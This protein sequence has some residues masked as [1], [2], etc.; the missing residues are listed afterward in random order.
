MKHHII[1]SLMLLLP[2]AAFAQQ[3]DSE[4]PQFSGD[5]LLLVMVDFPNMQFQHSAAEIQSAVADYACNGKRVVGPYH[6]PAPP[7]SYSNFETTFLQFSLDVYDSAAAD[8][9]MSHF[10]FDSIHKNMVIVY[11]GTIEAMA[12]QN[13]LFS[14]IITTYGFT[15]TDKSLYYVFASEQLFEGGDEHNGVPWYAGDVLW[16][17][18]LGQTEYAAPGYLFHGYGSSIIERAVTGCATIDTLT[19]A[20]DSIELKVVTGHNDKGYYISLS[21]DEFLLLEAH[22]MRQGSNAVANDGMYIFHGS[23]SIYTYYRSD[24]SSIYNR[25][26]VPFGAHIYPDTVFYYMDS[27]DFSCGLPYM[28][29]TSLSPQSSVKPRLLDTT[30]VM[31]DVW[32]TNIRWKNGLVTL[33]STIL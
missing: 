32:I 24:N 3:N 33:L 17:K 29:G 16:I 31:N 26:Y 21:D 13:A 10:P 9:D 15:G 27:A 6:M 1:I 25:E 7:S 28:G 5:S 18:I 14:Q 12:Q 20:A 11:P 30:A 22:A 2:L 8:V 4:Y 23:D 19:A